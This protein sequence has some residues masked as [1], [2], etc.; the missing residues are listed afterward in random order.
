VFFAGRV[1]SNLDIAAQTAGCLIGILL[2]SACGGALTEWIR[3]TSAAAPGDRLGRL[4]TAFV[5]GWLFVNLAPFDITVDLGDLA[6]RVR[7]GRIVIVPF[8]DLWE[9]SSARVIWDAVA[10]CLAAVPVGAAGVVAWRS[11]RL[12]AF[13]YGAAIITSVEMA[14][15]FISSHSATSTDVVFGWIGVAIGSVIGGRVQS[16]PA[17]AG[18]SPPH[19][20]VSWPAIAFVAGWILVLCAYHWQPY[21][22]ALD[23]ELIRRKLGHISLMPFA[24]YASGSYLNAFN[25]LLTKLALAAPLGVSLALVDRRVGRDGVATI[26]SLAATVGVFATIELGQ[27][28]LPTRIPDPSDVLVGLIGAYAGIRLGGWLWS[29]PPRIS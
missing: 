5:V 27:L 13:A 18:T 22:F 7:T 29:P 16:K 12:A 9:L 28:F 21:E 8:T 3:E 1:P 17:S 23:I 14:Q 20:T 15:V 10:E 4:L 11:T 24:G 19:G 2:W 26:V 6:R 25:N